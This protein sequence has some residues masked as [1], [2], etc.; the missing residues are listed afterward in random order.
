MAVLVVV[1]V[2]L[3]GTTG[4][5]LYRSSNVAESPGGVVGALAQLRGVELLLSQ[6]NTGWRPPTEA[7][8]QSMQ[9]GAALEQ[10]GRYREALQAYEQARALAPDRVLVYLAMAS[11]HVS[12]GETDQA[13][14][15][16]ETAEGLEPGNA[17][18]QRTLGRLRCMRGELEPCLEALEKA[19]EIEPDDRWGRFRLASAY[20]RSATDGCEE[21]LAQYQEALRLDPQFSEAHLG[22]AYLYRSQP[23]KDALSFEEFDKALDAALR[24]GNDPVVTTAQVELAGIYYARD[25]YARCIEASEQVLESLPSEPTPHFRLGLCY[26]MRGRETSNVASRSCRR[27]CPWAA[28]T[29]KS[30]SSSWAG[31]MPSIRTFRGRSGLG[32]SS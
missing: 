26:A 30:I 27:Q 5:L 17:E 32:S 16:L 11:A 24:A 14:V 9:E 15:Y 20:Q 12:L 4:W 8:A 21:A 22:L 6:L 18:V 29:S 10:E 2:V 25:D 31:T 3:T 23:G 1:V 28:A 19:A 7:A 13:L